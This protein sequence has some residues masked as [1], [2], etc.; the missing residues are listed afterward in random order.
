MWDILDY[1]GPM[2]I[3]QLSRFCHDLSGCSDIECLTQ[4]TEHR[5]LGAVN[6]TRLPFAI[7]IGIPAKMRLQTEPTYALS[8]LSTMTS[9]LLQKALMNALRL[10]AKNS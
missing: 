2:L 9:I 6:S 8:K 3:D 5:V 10:S 7:F 1:L 4:P